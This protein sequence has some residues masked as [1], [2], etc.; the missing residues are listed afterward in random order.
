MKNLLNNI[1][2]ILISEEAGVLILPKFIRNRKTHEDVN[3]VLY[4]LK[5]FGWD[6]EGYYHKYHPVLTG[7][8]G[9]YKED[10][11]GCCIGEHDGCYI[12]DGSIDG[13]GFYC[14]GADVCEHCYHSTEPA[15]M[16]WDEN[17]VKITA[18]Y[19]SYKIQYAAECV[20]Y[21][22]ENEMESVISERV[23]KE[24][25]GADNFIDLRKEGA[26]FIDK[27]EFINEHERLFYYKLSG[28]LLSNQEFMK[29]RE[30][31][32]G[33]NAEVIVSLSQK[34]DINNIDYFTYLYNF[35]EL[36]YNERVIRK[37]GKL[38]ENSAEVVLKYNLE[39]YREITHHERFGFES[40]FQYT[41]MSPEDIIQE[42]KKQ[43]ELKKII[44]LELYNYM[45]DSV[46]KEGLQY[47]IDKGLINK[48][49]FNYIKN[50]SETV[51]NMGIGHAS[52]LSEAETHKKYL[53]SLKEIL[54]KQDK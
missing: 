8:C 48:Q 19:G 52:H 11:D 15:R 17:Y 41:I 2:K 49:E 27:V 6:F 34:V 43:L 35:K 47:G 28:N 54:K 4:L 1:E 25:Y 22:T 12:A 33:E 42:V 45:N 23:K 7:N 3:I 18:S 30:K 20:K 21:I 36:R 38:V 51:R 40:L 53:E 39:I 16:E 32:T 9:Y 50:Y 13:S 24:Y 10:E 5:E 26:M 46:T 31:R 14:N 44:P 37:S 29:E